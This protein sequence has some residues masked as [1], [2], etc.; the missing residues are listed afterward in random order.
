MTEETIFNADDKPAVA[1]ETTAVTDT[2]T[3]AL[4]IPTELQGMIGEGKKYATVEAALASIPHAQSHISTLETENAAMKESVTASKSVKELIDDLRS[5]TTSEETPSKVEVNQTDIAAIVA[6]ELQ[7]AD[8][9][10]TKKQNQ[11]TVA[12][13]FK[14]KFGEKGEEKYNKLANDSG[15]SIADLNILASTSPSAIFK[16]AGLDNAGTKDIPPTTGGTV[17]TQALHGDSSENTTSKVKT[18]NTKDV[19]VGWR[20]AG[21]MAKKKY[22]LD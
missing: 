9:N 14:E 6:Q 7:K 5:T 21:E 11:T 10:K 2:Q 12:Q 16:M 4:V 13:K 1:T 8:K 18:F 17:N 3:P 15:L 20:I 22:G 19:A